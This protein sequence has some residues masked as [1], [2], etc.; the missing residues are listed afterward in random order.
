MARRHY[1]DNDRASA[2]AV[3]AA[4]NGNLTRTSRETGVPLTTLK[5]WSDAPDRAAPSEVRSEKA[6]D[7]MA[8]FQAELAAVFDAMGRRRGQAHYSDLSRAAGIFT[9]KMMALGNNLPTQPVDI[10]SGGKPI[11]S[12][13]DA[14]ALLRAAY[15]DDDPK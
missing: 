4:N 9:D 14:L 11:E 2:L 12:T 8:L 10:T 13:A 15:R 5:A 3:L 7:L 6:F 1:S